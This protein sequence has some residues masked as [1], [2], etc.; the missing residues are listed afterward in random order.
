MDT[1]PLLFQQ[2]RNAFNSVRISKGQIATIATCDANGVPN[3]AP[4]GSMRV[5]DEHTVHVLQGSLPRTLRNLQMNPKAAFSVTLPL[6]TWGGLR[7]LFRSDTQEPLG[8]RIYCELMSIEE[9]P[10]LVQMEA[11]EIAGRVPRLLRG[12]FLR[13]CNS[14]LKRLW[15]F[16]ILE[17]RVT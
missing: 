7:S 9:E 15:R 8:Y 3:L 11:R 13:F 16:R 4:I 2:A 10:S 17:V 12:G 14:N 5:V 6:T 1:A